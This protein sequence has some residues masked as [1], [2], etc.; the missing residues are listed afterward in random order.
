MLAGAGLAA[1]AALVSTVSTARAAGASGAAKHNFT[2]CLNTSTIRG[3]HLGIEGELDLAAKAGYRAVEPW[4][5]PI[6]DYVKQGKSLKDLRKRIDDLGITIVSAI[7]FPQWAVDDD[8]ARAKGL[9]QAKADMDVVAQLGGTRIAAPPAGANKAP[10]IDLYKIA[11]R[12]RALLELGDKMGVVPELEFWGP[13]ANL[14]RLSE[15]MF[16]AM[17]AAHPKAC[18]LADVYHL[19][20]GGSS[21][22]TLHMAN[23]ASIVT[24]HMN[25]Y[26]ADPPI[27]RIDD[28][29]RVFPGDGIAPLS[30]ILRTLHES[31]AHTNLSLELFNKD[32]WRQD[33]LKVAQT[34]LEKMKAA[35]EKALA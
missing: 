11:E 7:A 26:P 30:R 28:S 2:F 8:A 34:G 17:E 31:G 10:V 23:G 20:K 35:V 14:K 27:D 12:Y 16:C 13:S 3:H 22:D 32:Y 5:Q 9:E 33:A 25:D 29:F 24:L 15:A 4:L 21:I 19:Y 1:G 6:N 18:V